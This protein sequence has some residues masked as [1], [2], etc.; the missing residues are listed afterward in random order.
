MKTEIKLQ[1]KLDWQECIKLERSKHCNKKADHSKLIKNENKTFLLWYLVLIQATVVKVPRFISTRT[2][3]FLIKKASHN[4]FWDRD[5]DLLHPHKLSRPKILRCL[6]C[7]QHV[8]CKQLPQQ[9]TYNHAFTHSMMSDKLLNR[10]LSTSNHRR[11]RAT[12]HIK[13]RFLA[14]QTTWCSWEGSSHTHC[15][16]CRADGS[17]SEMKT[18]KLSI[19]TWSVAFM[20][21]GRY[22]TT[23][24]HYSLS[25]YEQRTFCSNHRNPSLISTCCCVLIT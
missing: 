18:V 17:W 22:S 21:F 9:Q 19:R 7:S 12:L 4:A 11:R 8:Y 1:M 15:A 13:V 24:W 2:D 20:I 25:R 23:L 10:N 3:H 16:A 14:Q 6:Q 5:L